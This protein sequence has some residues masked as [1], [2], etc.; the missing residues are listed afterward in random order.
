MYSRI[1]LILMD[2]DKVTE[3]SKKIL[4]SPLGLASDIVGFLFEDNFESLK[5]KL[6]GIKK[7][8]AGI[9]RAESLAQGYSLARYYPLMFL[10]HQ[11]FNSSYRARQGKVLE[12]M[13]KN[14]VVDFVE[15]Y[16]V[17]DKINRIN[18][19]LGCVFDSKIP[20]LDIDVLGFN[21][22]ENKLIII[23]LRSR[24][25]TGGTTAKGS[26]VDMLR[27]L[28]RLEKDIKYDILYLVGVWDARDS[29]QKKSTISK[30]YSSLKDWI[31]V[32]KEEFENGID[33]GV[34]V[35]PKI[36]LQMAYGTDEIGEVIYQFSAQNNK[37]ILRGISKVIESVEKWDGLWIAYS[38][39]NLEIE[40][41]SFQGVSNIGLLN[42]KCA[43]LDIKLGHSSYD[44]LCKSIEESGVKL[45]ENWNENSIPFVGTGDRIQYIKDLLFLKECYLR[46]AK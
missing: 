12:E 9:D 1:F 37:E 8:V 31:K 45:A 7:F 21:E 16:A 17:P 38:V 25:D 40:I 36:K 34:Y 26:L 33:N 24:D 4:K 32:S 19:I 14:I 28:L 22:K 2:G 13:I 27:E 11:H 5:D 23:Q 43:E 15:G 44:N 10:F 18:E 29:Q 20:R 35:V 30:M 46:G 42:K 6:D 3:V 39:A 41:K